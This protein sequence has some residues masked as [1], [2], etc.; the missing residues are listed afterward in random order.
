[1]HLY[2]SRILLLSLALLLNLVAQAQDKKLSLEEAVLKQRSTLAPKRLNQWQWTSDPRYY[3]WVD[4]RPDPALLRGDVQSSKE[5]VVLPLS[6]LNAGLRGLGLDTLSRF[7]A[8]RWSDDGKPRFEWQKKILEWDLESA[9]LLL[10]DSITLPEEAEV[11]E[12]ANKDLVAYVFD[13][14]IWIEAGHR[15]TQVT[16]DGSADLVYGKTVHREEFGI[17]KGLFWSPKGNKLAFYRM[18]Q[19]MVSTYPIVDFSEKP[20]KDNAIKY[21]FSGGR[22]HEVTVGLYDVKTGKTLYLQTEGPAEQYLTNIAWSPDERFVYV[23]IVNRAQDH[24]DLIRYSAETGKADRKLFEE[25]DPRYTEPLHPVQFVNEDNSRF[26]WQSRR[27]GWN[28]LYLYNDKGELV[29]QLTKGDWEVTEFNG[30]DP[31]GR[32]G[33]FHRTAN[34]GLNREFCRVDLN[35]AQLTVLANGNGI[36]NCLLNKD[37]SFYFSSFSNP[38]TPRIQKIGSIDGKINRTLLTAQD[39]LKEYAVGKTRLF[40]IKADD[41]TPLWCRMVLPPAFDSTKTYPVIVYLYGGPHL[42]LITN[43]WLAGADLWYHY[44]AQKGYIVFTLDNRGSSNR[45]KEFEQATFRKLGDVEMKDQIAGINYLRTLSYVDKNRLGIHGWSYGGFMTTSLMTRYPGIFKVAVAGGPVIDWSY[46][47]VMY[48]ER[49]MDKPEE[50]EPGYKMSNLLNYVDQLN[51]RLMLIHGTSDDVVVWQHSL[52]YLKKAISK[53]VQ[54][55]YMVY[56]GH[57]HNV[58]GKDRVHLMEKITRYFDDFLK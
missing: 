41:G 43:T 15:K 49:Y 47:E 42:Q 12:R 31:K 7:P 53:G 4:E 8:C 3:S 1:M 55:D 39:P 52:M 33:Y 51:G 6:A 13:R 2:I 50:N 17:D 11:A 36:T 46:Y 23:A 32:F 57:A 44:M 24:M 22:S 38:T 27:D 28:H 48:T 30:F 35:S 20:A 29:R 18:D 54:V 34:T 9:K 37:K 21:P 14:N 56:P 10:L 19:S 26:L 40:S 45:G 25:H 58:T 16:R 5:I